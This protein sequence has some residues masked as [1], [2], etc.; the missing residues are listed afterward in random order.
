[1]R[2]INKDNRHFIGSKRLDRRRFLQ[3]LVLSGA[4]VGCRRVDPTAL[5]G[6]PTALSA[7][8]MLDLR[9]MLENAAVDY[10]PHPRGCDVTS[11]RGSVRDADGSPAS[12]ITVHVWPDDVS[13]TIT[14]STDESGYYSCDVASSTTSDAFHIQL[15][16]QT[17]TTL[18]SEVIVVQAAAHCDLNLMTVNFVAMQ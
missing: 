17:G 8:L 3:F 14:L 11:I 13:R 18:Y 12:G 1:M 7:T 16:D 15:T 5:I 9:Y 10:G 4:V 6:T 2:N